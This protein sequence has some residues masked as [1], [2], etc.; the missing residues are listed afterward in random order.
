MK[1]P[2]HRSEETSIEL[3][4]K[5][6]ASEQEMRERALRWYKFWKM[7]DCTKPLFFGFLWVPVKAQEGGAISP[8]I[9]R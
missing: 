6:E 5:Q 3:K 8:K 7:G 4:L 1:H 2:T 9:P